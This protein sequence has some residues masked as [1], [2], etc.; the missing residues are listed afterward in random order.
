MTDVKRW[1]RDLPVARKL[2]AI[3]VA[4]T[5]TTVLAA[6]VTILAYDISS[7]RQRLTREVELLADVIG[8]NSTAALAFGD[9]STA[10]EILA[11]VAANDHIMAATIRLPDG[12]VFARYV[13]QG[14]ATPAAED[15]AVMVGEPVWHWIRNRRLVLART[16]RL[17]GEAVGSLAVTSD[18]REIETRAVQFGGIV[19]VVLIGAVVMAFLL[20]WRL[21]G[22][23]STPLLRLTA[24]ARTVTSEHR[25]D[26]QVTSAGRDEIG[27]LIDRFNEM[28]REI[29]GRDRQLLEHQE[30]LEQTVDTRTTELRE[31]NADLTSARDRAME[32]SRAKS[33]F[34]ANMSHEIR[35]PMNGIIGMTELALDT[36]LDAQQR[37]YLSTV[38]TS[39]DSLLAILNDILDFSK[40]ESRK[41]ELE[42][43]PFSLRELVAQTVKPLALKADQKGLEL[44]YE[45]DHDVPQGIVGDPGRLRQVLSNLIGN[46][47]KFTERGH[48]VLEIKQENHQPGCT[49]LHF[50]VSDTGIGIARDK[51]ATVFEAFS[52]ADGSTTRRFGG[53]GLGLTISA[54]LVQMMGG[55]IWVES[56][57]GR[58][59]VFHFTVPFDTATLP[60][61]IGSP[62]PVLAGLPV[63]VVDDNPVNRRILQAQLL[64]WQ[65]RPTCV[66]TGSLAIQALI[67]GA[68]AGTPFALVLLDANMPGMDGFDVAREIGSDPRLA[69]LTIVMLTSSGQYG[70]ATRS[71]ELGISSYLTKPV[72]AAGLHDAICR[73]L[74]GADMPPAIGLAPAAPAAVRPLHILLAEDNVVNQRVAAG[75]LEKRGHRVTIASNGREALTVLA[76]QSV[77]LVLMDIQ[78]PEMGGFEATQEI[79]RLEAVS[80]ARL[81]IVAMTAHAMTGDRERCLAAGMDDYVSKPIEPARFFAAVEMGAAPAT[82]PAE[83]PPIALG[84]AIDREALMKRV[85]GDEDLF[86][87]IVQLFLVDCPTRVAAIH[88]AVA[89]G[90]PEEV[91]TAA[92]ALKGSAGNLSATALTAAARTL[93]RLGSERRLQ[94]APAA[95]RQLTAQ[96][97]LAMDLLQEWVPALT[98]AP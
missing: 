90:D 87:E 65:S 74:Q 32:A 3:G 24:A 34:L 62:A 10:A 29:Q 35:T 9:T 66:A 25:Y 60:P 88:A 28:L 48:V 81:R 7:S 75:L 69:G 77:D 83:P 33:E 58:G 92:H 47:T 44:L 91:R 85:G 53:T 98:E 15:A 5:A 23:I 37:D 40:V 59:S 43:I 19:L 42:R 39:A 52:Q 18:V 45:V 79:R 14:I 30:R 31:S 73:V 41:L 95:L 80:G 2:L 67:A 93:E 46:A 22:T 97:L 72:D 16:I 49:M 63:L 70:D 55:R 11:S 8:A 56:E 13:R 20:V 1:F 78:M 4:T 36:A 6:C 82:A 12:V 50:S 76:A 27:E 94:S 17:K 89:G 86:R 21:Q 61:A 26:L 71:R 51:Q 96:A 68:E 84:P 38:K 54:T 57:P 64:R